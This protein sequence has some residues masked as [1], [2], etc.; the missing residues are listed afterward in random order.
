[1]LLSAGRNPN[2]RCIDPQESFGSRGVRDDQRATVSFSYGIGEG[3][4]GDFVTPIRPIF[5]KGRYYFIMPLHCFFFKEEQA[6]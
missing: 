3:V 2:Q 4:K 5:V 1:M 6:R